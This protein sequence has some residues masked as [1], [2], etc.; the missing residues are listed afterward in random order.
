MKL[1]H[2]VSLLPLVLFSA[3][4]LAPTDGDE[5]VGDTAQAASG[6]RFRPGGPGGGPG[7][8]GGPG[9]GR[10]G[11]AG[12]VR[13]F[14]G[15]CKFQ[16]DANGPADAF[17]IANGQDLSI[18]FT[19]LGEGTRRPGP[20]GMNESRCSFAMPIDVPAGQFL[21]GWSQSL[22]Y[23][24]VKPAGVR[25]GLG[26]DSAIQNAGASFPTGGG[27]QL[28][29]G[30]GSFGPPQIGPGRRLGGG[31]FQLPSIRV[32][33]DG[34]AMNVPLAVA[35]A[36]TDGFTETDPRYNQWRSRWCAAGRAQN[37][38]FV[39]SAYTWA[40]RTLPGADPVIIA[41]DGLD[42]RFDLGTTAEAC[43]VAPTPPPRGPMPQPPPRGPN[44]Q[45][46]HR[47]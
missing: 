42:A 5:A 16:D 36:P 32:N 37:V 22:Q 38:E 13:N 30:P 33:F 24:I 34:P 7:G 14:G 17:T 29:G 28:P 35:T 19:K 23:G 21:S 6:G 46:P 8:P 40:E 11:P 44:P 27:I 4:C 41:I 3:A 20:N 39:G 10:G 26:L 15:A 9:G 2:L 12:G 18:V 31:M 47:H 25:A 43:P 45:L 1:V